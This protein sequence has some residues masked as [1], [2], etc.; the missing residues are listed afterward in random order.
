MFTNIGIAASGGVAAA[1]IIG[2]SIFPTMLVQWRGD[3]WRG[4]E[5]EIAVDL[6]VFH[7]RVTLTSE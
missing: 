2:V 6:N 3:R 1:L 4:Q 5:K 7:K